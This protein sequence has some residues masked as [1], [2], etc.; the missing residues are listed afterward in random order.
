MSIITYLDFKG[1]QS[2]ASLSNKGT[3]ESLQVFI[4]EYEPK[5]LK[6]L[7]GDALAQ[8]FI[9]GLAGSGEPV[10]I[11]PIWSALAAMPALKTMLVCYVYYWYTRDAVTLTAGTGEVKPANENSTAVSSAPKQVKAWNKMVDLARGFNLDRGVYPAYPVKD[12]YFFN[13][14]GTDIYHRINSLNL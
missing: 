1:E 13:R 10:V 9:T 12:Y 4:D 7:L 8:E 3:Q 11:D 6:S 2:I 5:F 14:M